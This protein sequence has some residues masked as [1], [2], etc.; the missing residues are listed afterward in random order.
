MSIAYIALG[1]NMGN[2]RENFAKAMTL[3]EEQGVVIT[4]KSS[5]RVTKP[6]G[7]LDQED[8]LNGVIEVM[9]NKTAQELLQVVLT[10]ENTMGR[11]RKRHWGERNIDLDIIWFNGDIINEPNLIIPHPDMLNRE[12]VLAP[13][14]ELAGDVVHPKVGKTFKELLEELQRR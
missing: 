5:F 9:W 4:G 13:L 10:V 12:F 3:L 7:V 6:Y 8:F 2:R 1:S 11:V 14:V